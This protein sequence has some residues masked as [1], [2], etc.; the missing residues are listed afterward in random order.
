M[1]PEQL[2]GHRWRAGSSRMSNSSQTGSASVAAAV[3][4]SSDHTWPR[5]LFAG[6]SGTGSLRSSDGPGSH[7]DGS[8]TSV[9]ST[10][11]RRSTSCSPATTTRVGRSRKT[12]SS[13][14]DSGHGHDDVARGS[15]RMKADPGLAAPGG[16]PSGRGSKKSTSSTG[17]RRSANIVH[18]KSREASIDADDGML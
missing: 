7:R 15:P 17:S 8:V 11:S 2:E 14:V 12:R 4:S 3:N 10:N 6:A 5:R 13:Q 1:H 9:S 16:P 18:V